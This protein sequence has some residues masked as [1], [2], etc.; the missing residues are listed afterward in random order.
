MTAESMQHSDGQRVTPV[1]VEQPPMRFSRD[2]PTDGSLLSACGILGDSAAIHKLGQLLQKLADTEA[3]VLIVGETGTGKELV[4][5]ALHMQSRRSKGPFIAINCAAVPETLLESELF[6]HA[7]GAFTDASS[8]KVGL[9]EQ[10]S[11]GTLFLDEIGE[12]PPAMQAKLL[13]A[14]QERKIRAVGGAVE[15]EF[16]ARIIAATNKD[17]GREVADGRFRAD[18]YYRINVVIVEVPPLRD[19]GDDLLLLAQRFVRDTAARSRKLV[20]GL[21]DDAVRVL[22]EYRWP[23][24]VRELQNSIERAVALCD[25]AL[26]TANELPPTIRDVTE[27]RPTLPQVVLERDTLPSLHEVEQRYVRYVLEH[28][29]NNKTHAARLLGI[30]RKTLQRKLDRW[31][32]RAAAKGDSPPTSQPPASQSPVSEVTG[33]GNGETKH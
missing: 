20:R 18:L 26:V 30:D 31:R 5:R 24:N 28:T 6:G 16:D 12:I 15:R 22:R 3:T 10:A 13:R 11:G 27:R 1:G 32:R 2:V 19:R 14:L 23:G 4:A 21:S 9:F 33:N 17:L 7:K 8:D 25:G 29:G